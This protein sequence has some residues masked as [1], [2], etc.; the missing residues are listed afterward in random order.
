MENEKNTKD[1]KDDRIVPG[2]W[3]LLYFGAQWCS[4]CKTME[5][6]MQQVSSEFKDKIAVI[7]IDVDENKAMADEFKVAS[8]PTLVLCHKKQ[9]R[10]RV[11]GV[12]THSSIVE[13]VQFDIAKF[14]S[15]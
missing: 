4:P 3:E 7:K 15:E 12:R 10:L 11:V 8:I 14:L 1:F 6:I 9:E 13:L 5:P 2:D